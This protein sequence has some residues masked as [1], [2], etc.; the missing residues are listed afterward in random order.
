M[1]LNRDEELTT[2]VDLPHPRQYTTDASLEFSALRAMLTEDIRGAAIAAATHGQD[3]GQPF[4][5]NRT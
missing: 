4:S 1:F 2:P 3:E 5:P